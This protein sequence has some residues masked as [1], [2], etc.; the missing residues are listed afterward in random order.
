MLS[1]SCSLNYENGGYEI[2]IQ[3]VKN[4][5]RFSTYKILSENKSS[6][7]SDLDVYQYN[8]LEDINK[9]YLGENTTICKGE[10]AL[11]TERIIYLINK[12]L[13]N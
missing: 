2:N 13:R 1:P 11:R 12:D 10:E 6:I 8:V 5:P 9:D 3:Y 4:D 7:L